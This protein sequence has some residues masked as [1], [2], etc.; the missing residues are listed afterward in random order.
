MD[1]PFLCL[2]AAS[3]KGRHPVEERLLGHEVWIT[4]PSAW[5]GS[6]CALLAEAYQGAAGWGRDDETVLPNEPFDLVEAEHR[7]P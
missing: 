1:G 7:R 4:G 6:E 5:G 2:P 3:A